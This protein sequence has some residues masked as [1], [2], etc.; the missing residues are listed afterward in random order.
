MGT[1]VAIDIKGMSCGGCVVA[2][3][4]V[5]ARQA[6][7][8]NVHVEVGTAKID[9]D[10]AQAQEAPIRAAITRAGFEVTS[11]AAS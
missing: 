1:R 3:R 4:N 8:A 9:V 5:L 10:D 6:G 11:F 7:V 2:L